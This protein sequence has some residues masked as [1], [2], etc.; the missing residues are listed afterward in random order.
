MYYEWSVRGHLRV[1]DR[2]EG[3]RDSC[4]LGEGNAWEAHLFELGLCLRHD[5][6]WCVYLSR[7]LR[8]ILVDDGGVIEH[9]IVPSRCV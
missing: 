6:G 8:R 9:R 5:Y 3:E 7:S 4:E 1:R 2:E